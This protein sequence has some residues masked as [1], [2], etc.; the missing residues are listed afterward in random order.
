MKECPKCQEQVTG[1]S[2]VCLNCGYC[3]RE[4]LANAK[5][6]PN[7][8][9]LM[10]EKLRFCIDCG[11]NLEEVPVDHIGKECPNCQT[12]AARGDNFCTTCGFDMSLI[13]DPVEEAAAST[14]P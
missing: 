9:A 3:F 11:T 12:I 5:E 6:C 4:G 8:H 2:V 1:T 10:S 14:V 13:P 7:C